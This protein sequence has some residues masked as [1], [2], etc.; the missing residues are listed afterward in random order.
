MSTEAGFLSQYCTLD[1]TC[2]RTSGAGMRKA[3]RLNPGRRR[4]RASRKASNRR[5]NSVRDT[6]IWIESIT[7]T[8]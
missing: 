1:E 6:S 2:A 8:C 4:M 7:C 5:R 3:G